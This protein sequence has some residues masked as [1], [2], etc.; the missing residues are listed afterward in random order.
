MKL[1][2]LRDLY[3]DHLRDLLDAE[4]QITKALPKMAKAASS[5]DLQK[6]FNDHLEQTQGHVQRLEQVFQ[7]LGM[8]ARGKKCKA[9]EGLIAEGQ[10]LMEEDAEPEV[11]D[12][13]MIAAAQ[14][15]EHYEMAG[16]GTLRTYAQIL[17]LKDQV[18][19]LQQTLDEEG[20][21]DKLLTQI[22]ERHINAD[23]ASGEAKSGGKR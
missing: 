14:R 3:V 9:M 4:H 7:S 13:G 18:K 12:A 10:E 15:I 23:A 20:M 2:T 22:A 19:L 17:G 21:A 16:Y 11:L 8:A 1:D 6:A 5:P